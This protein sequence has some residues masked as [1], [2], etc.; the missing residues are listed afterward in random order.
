MKKALVFLGIGIIIL[1]KT[2][3][4]F[5]LTISPARAELRADPGTTV[6][7][8]IVLINDQN[9]TKTFYASFENFVAD[10]DGGT[11]KFVGDREGL[12]TWFSTSEAVVLRPGEAKTIPFTVSVPKGATPG[13]YF[14]GIFWSTTSPKVNQGGEL[15]VGAK[16]G[17]LVFL[18]VN[19]DI[20]E[21]AGLTEFQTR[22]KNFFYSALP[23]GFS[24]RF[25]NTGSDRVKP[26]GDITIRSIL[27]W[28]VAKVPANPTE[29]NVLPGT[30]RRFSPVWMKD[31]QL[32][33]ENTPKENYSFF[34]RV[35]YQWNNFAVGIFRAKMKVSYGFE[36]QIAKSN[37]VYFIVFPWELLLILLVG[38][39]GGVFVVRRGLRRYNAYIIRKAQLPLAK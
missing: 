14:S 21:S 17:M 1:S 4:V 24:Y 23:V 16:I 30:T 26:L 32:Q 37:A 3:S 8:D 39:S 10:G 18:S 33:E 36:E 13:G 2:T 12:A 5:A 7:G 25:T 20:K 31:A 35:G 34:K 28:R 9:D 19:G 22:N 29:G 27:G 15:A 6:G 38:G 11:P